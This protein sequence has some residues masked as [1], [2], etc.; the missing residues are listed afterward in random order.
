MLT[1]GEGGTLVVRR[2][3][4]GCRQFSGILKV[5]GL[6]GLFVFFLNAAEV[7]NIFQVRAFMSSDTLLWKYIRRTRQKMLNLPSIPTNTDQ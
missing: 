6:L 7:A 1:S 5:F 3:G 2:N 4:N